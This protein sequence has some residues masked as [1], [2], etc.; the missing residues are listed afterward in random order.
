MYISAFPFILVGK[1]YTVAVLLNWR[2]SNVML[3]YATVERDIF[4][5]LFLVIRN[6]TNAYL[7]KFIYYSNLNL[8]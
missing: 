5:K 1:I 8:T 6:N 7:S 3:G 4:I 2:V